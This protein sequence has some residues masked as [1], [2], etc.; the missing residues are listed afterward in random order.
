MSRLED[1]TEEEF[2][3]VKE[4]MLERLTESKTVEEVKRGYILGGQSGAGKTTLHR[5]FKRELEDNCIIINGDEFRP[6]HP[7]YRE[8]KEEYGEDAVTKLSKFSGQMVEELVDELSEEGYNLIIEGTLRTS[9]VPLKTAKKLKENGYEVDLGLIAV[10]PQISYLSTIDRYEKM[11][12]KGVNTRITPKDHHDKIVNSLASNVDEIYKTKEFSNIRIYDREENCLYNQN[13]TP[14]INPADIMDKVLTG[15]YS[16]K[17]FNHLLDIMEE[18]IYLKSKRHADDTEKY[19][20]KA[21]E[22]IGIY[23]MQKMELEKDKNIK[24]SIDNETLE[25]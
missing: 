13:E 21:K 18:I 23:K 24:K 19:K 1:Y 16:E 12:D 17:E 9:E 7:R 25:R 5:I 20:D 6:Y 10:K 11:L 2:L 14:E 3:E 22:I 4:E 15:K 8:L